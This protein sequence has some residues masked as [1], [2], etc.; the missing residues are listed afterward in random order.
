MPERNSED[1]AEAGLEHSAYMYRKF[2]NQH[3]SAENHTPKRTPKTESTPLA[4]RIYLH[5]RELQEYEF[6]GNRKTAPPVVRECGGARLFTIPSPA[7]RRGCCI[8]VALPVS[9]QARSLVIAGPLQAGQAEVET[10]TNLKK[11]V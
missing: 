5:C 11:F 7:A 4:A 1:G 3:H 10:T 2:C 8:A 9:N 6:W